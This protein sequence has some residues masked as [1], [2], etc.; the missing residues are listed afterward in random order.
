MKKSIFIVLILFPLIYF[1]QTK[2]QLFQNK[3]TEPYLHFGGSLNL[4]SVNIF[5]NYTE[6][7]YHLGWSIHSS[8]LTKNNLRFTLEYFRT[9][10]F[11]LKPTWRDVRSNNIVLSLNALAH[12]VDQDVIIYTVSGICFQSWK[13]FY[14]GQNDFSDARFYYTENTW[15]K[16]KNLC[17]DLGIGFEKPFPGFNLYGDFR[18]RFAKTDNRFGIIDAFYQ[19]GLNFPIYPRTNHKNNGKTKRGNFF[20]KLNDKYNWF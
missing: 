10:P 4:S 14:T 6:N 12:I 9:P 3:R 20:N 2:N 17:L 7:P 11:Q 16:N 1:A 8:Y 5:R 18:Y 13:G 19:L 15:V